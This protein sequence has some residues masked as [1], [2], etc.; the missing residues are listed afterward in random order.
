MLLVVGL[1]LCIASG[2]DLYFHCCKLIK[3]AE[4]AVFLEGSEQ[5]CGLNGISH[6]GDE[7]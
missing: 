6:F 3:I 1:E 2:K 5:V 4:V 7:T